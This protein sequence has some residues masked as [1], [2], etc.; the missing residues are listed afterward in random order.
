MRQFAM[1]AVWLTAQ[2][3]VAAQSAVPHN[4][5]P[6]APSGIGVQWWLR[7]GGNAVVH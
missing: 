5:R 1:L 3:A 6:D 7:C 4:Q 2:V